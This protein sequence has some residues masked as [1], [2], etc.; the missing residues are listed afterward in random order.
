M[1]GFQ[2]PTVVLVVLVAA[3]SGYVMVDVLQSYDEEKAEQVRETAAAYCYQ[4]FGDSSTYVAAVHGGHGGTH[5]VANGGQP[6]YHAV[7]AE[8]KR[9][10]LRA[11]RTGERVEWT[12]VDRYK[13]LG[14]RGGWLNVIRGWF[15]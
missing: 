3:V 13:P 12:D 8:A 10:A 1:T 9:A 6:H 4:A 5:C 14:D 7:T 11:N 2:T 15:A